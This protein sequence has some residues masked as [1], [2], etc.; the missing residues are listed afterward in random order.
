MS[1]LVNYVGCS[2]GKL[3]Q[4]MIAELYNELKIPKENQVNLEDL[5][6]TI[7]KSTD[8]FSFEEN[9]PQLLQTLDFNSVEIDF[10]NKKGDQL[11]L[12]VKTQ[13]C[14]DIFESLAKKHKPLYE[15]YIPHITIA[16]DLP[17]E[18][19]KTLPE[20]LTKLD[21]KYYP[22]ITSVYSKQIEI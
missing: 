17:V 14:D 7:F 22:I 5:H 21:L 16:R 20:R 8:L 12:L 4:K 6:I 2:L 3:T 13:F 9:Q 19:I 18:V 1:N 11:V 10:W 15:N